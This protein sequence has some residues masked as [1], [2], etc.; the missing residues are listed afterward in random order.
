MTTAYLHLLFRKKIWCKKVYAHF[1][2]FCKGCSLN[3]VF[4]PWNF[5]I[6]LNSASSVVALVFYLLVVCTH[7]DTEGKQRKARIRNILKSSEKNTIF[8]EHPVQYIYI[9]VYLSIHLSNFLSV[10]LFIYLSI[11]C[12]YICTTIY[13]SANFSYTFTVKYYLQFIY[14]CTYLYLSI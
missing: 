11:I 9:Y 14:L 2:G 10:Y 12:T 8:N 1:S 5:V 6:F 3:I 13:L 7:T 4:F